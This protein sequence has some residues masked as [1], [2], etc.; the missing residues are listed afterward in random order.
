[1]RRS[2]LLS[3]PHLI[4]VGVLLNTGVQAGVYSSYHLHAKP[5]LQI[6]VTTIFV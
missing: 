3:S 5:Y 1:M 2:P 6:N 4:S